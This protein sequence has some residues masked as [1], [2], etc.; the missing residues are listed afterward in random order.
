MKT[1][2][3][4]GEYT[5]KHWIKLMLTRN[6]ELPT[7]QRSFV[8]DEKDVKR[9]IDSLSNGQFVPPVT[10]A[11]YM[12]N[13]DST[14]LILDGQQRLTSLL[15]A[16]LG[17][18]PIKE[19]F[20][21][22]EYLA[23]GDDSREEVAQLPIEWQYNVLL[24]NA[25]NNFSPSE[26]NNYIQI[27]EQFYHKVEFSFS[28]EKDKFFDETFLGFSYIVH[29]SN[30][31]V[32]TQRFFSTLFRNMNYLGKSL[33]LLESRRSLYFMNIDYKNY[34]EGKLTNNED[35]L[36]DIHIMEN[37]QAQKIDFVR[38][39]SILSQYIGINNYS[40][41]LLG[42]SAYSSRESYYAD[43]VSYI[44]G[45][46]QEG[47]SDKFNMFNFS[48]TFP[49]N[50][51][52]D[53]FVFVRTFIENNKKDMGLKGEFQAFTSWI[54]ADYWLFGLLYY[55]L[56]KGKSCFKDELNLIS[57]IKAEIAKKRQNIDNNEEY[58]RNPNR[59]GNLR[60]RL[61]ISIN[62]YGKYV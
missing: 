48:D 23:Q 21:R 51:W 34:F 14:N 54:D 26:I 56:F 28:M 39:L 12:D 27:N 6:I 22:A 32:E 40:K 11:H 45:L 44:L 43:Y 59:L 46:E 47:R 31:S 30:D 35:V 10:I 13:G 52:R 58:L 49:D 24:E 36:C 60:N 38:Y 33:S 9:L 3:Y 17:Y 20:V 57:E 18:F 1:R 19:K 61:E 62:I 15:L 50:S 2:V 8:W 5:L 55:C 29:N 41:V 42:Y 25:N 37:K 4:Y 16:Y 53:R 7:Y